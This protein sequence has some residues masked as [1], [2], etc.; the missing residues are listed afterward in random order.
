MRP[1]RDYAL[2][3]T[4][5]AGRG[6]LSLGDSDAVDRDCNPNVLVGRVAGLGRWT[7][8]LGCTRNEEPI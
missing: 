4:R 1:P 5:R 3:G 6:R 7:V 2:Q 8:C